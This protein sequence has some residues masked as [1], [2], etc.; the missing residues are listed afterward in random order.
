MLWF[1]I[2][3]ASAL[4]QSGIDLFSKRGL[5]HLSPYVTSFSMAFFALPF[6]I[7]LLFLTEMPDLGEQ[8]WLVL[9]ISGSLGVL[10]IFLFMKAIQYSPLSLTVPMFAFTPVFLLLTSPLIISEYPSLIGIGGAILVTAGAYILNLQSNNRANPMRPFIA[11]TKERGPLL[12]LIVALLLSIIVNVDKI[13]ITNSN[14]IVWIT[15]INL[16]MSG[17]F[18]VLMVVK[19]KN[20]FTVIKKNIKKLFPIGMFLALTQ[21]TAM[22]AYTLTL[23]PYAIAVKRSSIMFTSIFGMA[24]FHERSS[25]RKLIAIGIMLAGVFLI[26]FA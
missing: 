2:A 19:I 12:M 5:E 25:K 15:A 20:P 13:G 6:T 11:M 18:L 1:L 9:V 21:I 16:Y 24:F 3:I 17:I 10:M 26:L 4:T 23:V 7:P 22:Y 8:F 14:V